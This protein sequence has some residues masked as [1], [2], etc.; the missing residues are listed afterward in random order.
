MRKRVAAS[1]ARKISAEQTANLVHSGMWSHYGA[2]TAQ[3][4]A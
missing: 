2:I 3:P 4:D 1:I